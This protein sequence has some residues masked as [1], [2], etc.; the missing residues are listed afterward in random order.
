MN[1]R[2]TLIFAAIV[3]ALTWLVPLSAQAA[4]T[5]YIWNDGNNNWNVNADWTPNSTGTLG[6]S[7]STSAAT[8]N[9][10]GSGTPTTVTLNVIPT[11][12]SNVTLGNANN[13]LRINSGQSLSATTITMG[14]GSITGAGT[15]TNSGITGTGTVSS[16]L[17]GTTS[18]TASGGT[19]NASNATG[20]ITGSV[21]AKASGDILN[22][23]AVTFSGG[24]NT[25]SGGNYV[26]GNVINFN[27]TTLQGVTGLFS[28]TTL[29]GL[30]AFNVTGTST[31]VNNFAFGNL[32][33]MSVS[34][35]ATFKLSGATYGGYGTVTGGGN[36]TL[37]PARLWTIFPAPVP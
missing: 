28:S 27:G 1:T 25:F 35:G 2:K 21:N 19:L 23:G 5:T 3:L 12:L 7:G 36:M 37:N 32:S 15:V 16:A 20:T 13:T 30:G 26:G 34:S 8:I 11:K 9:N 29:Y 24:A 22:V 4:I 31:M 6:P 33:T 14:G 17:S 18:L 10:G